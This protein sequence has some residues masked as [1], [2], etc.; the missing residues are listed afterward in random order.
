MQ[1]KGY[2]MTPE[3]YIK[4]K[5]NVMRFCIGNLI[6]LMLSS[7]LFVAFGKEPIDVQKDNDKTVYTIG[8]GK[9]QK[10]EYQ[11]DKKNAWDMLKNMNI[12]LD[13]RKTAPASTP[14][15]AK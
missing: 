2:P 12:I 13:D 4:F 9:E 11:E 3:T 14:A 6:F 8:S 15:P 1:T 5:R 10:D 7:V